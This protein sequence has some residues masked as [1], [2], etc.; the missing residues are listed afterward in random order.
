[1]AKVEFG[2]LQKTSGSFFAEALDHES[3]AKF[4]AKV[5]ASAFEDAESVLVKLS[6]EALAD[7][8]SLAVDALS[9]AIPSGTQMYF[10]QSKEFALT[11]A[12]AAAGATSITV[13]ALPAT[14]EDNDEFY[15]KPKGTRKLIQAG[16]LVGRTIAE[17]DAGTGFGPA[18]VASDDEIF[19]I[20]FTIEDASLN[21]DVE[22][23]RHN[24]AVYEDLLPGW[25]GLPS[26]DQDKIRALYH[27]VK[28]RN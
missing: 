4:P 3:L 9:G 11:T 21:N 8:T 15:Y 14:I 22:L 16:T 1:M 6:A 18:V 2:T 10:G 19:L 17:R 28:S 24:F 23:L 25:S 26:G 5:L 7:A 27:C 20:A 13:Q 12:A